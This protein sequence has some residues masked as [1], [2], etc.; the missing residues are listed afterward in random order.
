MFNDESFHEYL[1]DFE[2]DFPHIPDTNK[3]D[4]NQ[5]D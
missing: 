5:F 2:A 3:A 1:S 4:F